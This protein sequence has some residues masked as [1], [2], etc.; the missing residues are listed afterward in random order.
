VADASERPV[1]IVI[2]RIECLGCAREYFSAA[3]PRLSR[4]LPPCPDC[5]A[6]QLLADL[7]VGE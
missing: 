6:D 7:I 2:A 5:G 3:V 4:P 1:E